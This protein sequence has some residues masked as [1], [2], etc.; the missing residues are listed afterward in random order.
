[1]N[2]EQ[3]RAIDAVTV[4]NPFNGELVKALQDPQLAATILDLIDVEA[5]RQRARD[6]EQIA[7][8]AHMINVG[9]SVVNEVPRDNDDVCGDDRTWMINLQR[10][11]EFLI[12]RHAAV[13]A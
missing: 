10:E 5:L 9:L 6:L 11:I 4:A 8:L 13:F 2:N 3:Q 7:T 12:K 1:M